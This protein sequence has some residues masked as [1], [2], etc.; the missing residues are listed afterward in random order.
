MAIYTIAMLVYQGVMNNIPFANE[1]IGIKM[2]MTWHIKW[3]IVGIRDLP[4]E[5]YCRLV[6]RERFG[7]IRSILFPAKKG[8]SQAAS[9]SFPTT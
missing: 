9:E 6:G 3:I 7:A 1:F 5:I 4:L 8:G 2:G